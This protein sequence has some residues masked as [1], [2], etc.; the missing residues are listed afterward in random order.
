MWQEILVKQIW[1]GCWT[2]RD[3]LSLLPC[4]CEWTLWSLMWFCAIQKTWSICWCL[5]RNSAKDQLPTSPRQDWAQNCGNAG[6]L[7]TSLVPCRDICGRI[8]WRFCVQKNFPKLP[9]FVETKQTSK[10]DINNKKNINKT[11]K[12]C[13]HIYW[14]KNNKCTKPLQVVFDPR[15]R[16][17]CPEALQHRHSQNGKAPGEMSW[18]FRTNG[19]DL[20][21]KMVYWMFLNHVLNMWCL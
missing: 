8:F 17:S 12:A 18:S 3:I 10:K 7:L 6:E 19:C 13:R 1:S 21:K 20:C 16:C 5:G 14:S 2:V 9:G 15:K 11:K 4:N